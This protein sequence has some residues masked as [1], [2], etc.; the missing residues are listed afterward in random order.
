MRFRRMRPS[1]LLA[2][3]VAL[4]C[5]AATLGVTPATAEPRDAARGP[6]TAQN[7][8][9]PTLLAAINAERQQRGLRPLR[10]SRDLARAADAHARAMGTNGFFAHESRDGT[11]ASTRIRR[12]YRVEGYS[13]W[14]TG[15][16]LLWRSPGVGASDAV[17]LWLASP[18]HRKILLAGEFRDVGI[19]AVRVTQATG[20]FG[21]R[22]VTIV[23]ADFGVRS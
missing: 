6:L 16:T 9:E 4:A 3:L 5:V 17:A 12:Y 14:L 7:A 15:E 8:L 2:L 19:A 13:R 10:P 18:P 1:R 22:N 11:S 21:G 20:A 23:V